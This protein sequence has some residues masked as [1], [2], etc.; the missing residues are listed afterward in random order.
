[1]NLTWNYVVGLF[2]ALTAAFI[3]GVAFA[4][5]PTLTP[6]QLQMLQQQQQQQHGAITSQ[7]QQ[8]SVTPRETIL[9]PTAPSA[10]LAQ[11]EM[12]RIL[13]T[14]SGM[15]LRQYGYDQLGVGRSV[16]LP[17][18]GAVQ[19]TYILG[20]G[21]EIVLTL[22]G[23]ENSEFRA[24][25][26][27]DGNV[28]F[29]R[30]QPIS[31]GGRSF[32]QF[33]Q[34]LAN[35][36]HRALVSTEGFVT[37]GRLRQIN[38]MVS[39][40]VG[41][42]GVRT[43]T[44]LSTVADAIFV[45]GGITKSGSL[46][47]V[48]LVRN[49]QERTVD[50][51][52]MLVGRV[53][54][55]N[56]TLTDGDKIIVPPVGATVAIAGEV[57]RPGIYELAAG[58]TTIRVRD[59][60]E[61]A[62][63]MTVPGSY[64]VSLLRTL[65]DGRRQMVDVTGGTGA[66]L[67]D[68]EIVFVRTSVNQSV[69]QVAIV[70]AVRAPGSAAIDKFKTIHDLLPSPD[71]LLPGAYL[72]FGFVER[73]DPVTLGRSVVPF[74]PIAVIQGK[75]NFPLKS[76]DTVHIL[77][78]DDMR[79]LID[80][81]AAPE[82]TTAATGKGPGV[83]G[84]GNAAAP[85]K[86]NPT[87]TTPS[88]GTTA[89]G[90]QAA[91]SQGVAQAVARGLEAAAANGTLPAGSA[92]D[93][94]ALAGTA[95]PAAAAAPAATTN[96][97]LV[98][99]DIIQGGLYGKIIADYRVI[100]SGA[101]HEP[102]IYLVYPGT[103]LSDLLVVAGGLTDDADMSSFELTSS[104]LDNKAGTSVTQRRVLPANSETFS[105]ILLKPYD[106]VVFHVIY[107]NR[108]FGA[109]KIAGEVLHPG[110]FDILRGEKLSSVLRRAGGFT[111]DGYAEGT[112]FRR[113]SVA[114]AEQQETD[115]ITADLRNQLLAYVMKPPSNNAQPLSA[116]AIATIEGLLVQV[117]VTR[118]MGRMPVVADLKALDEHPE[119]DTVLE[120]GDT[121]DIPRRPATVMIVGDVLRPGAQRYASSLSVGRYIEKAGGTSEQADTSRIIVVL[122]DGS[123]SSAGNSWL[124]FGSN[125]IPAGSTIYVPRKLEVY[126]FRQLLTDSIQIV[127][128]L[129]TTAAAL[130]VLSKQ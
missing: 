69:N 42:P 52:S 88:G 26:D 31:A 30:L 111:Q 6:D 83:P 33:R 92:G 37:I 2:G 4:Q 49:G 28:T 118:S 81:V 40:E 24:Q 48:R 101:V 18:I 119:L 102:G 23:Q 19:D 86:T 10:P 72:L 112:V 47:K 94:A 50:L 55:G 20:S 68:G 66:V 80:R 15:T 90:P 36:I 9:E 27:R 3:G 128:Q 56:F 105:S 91:A 74:S 25:V 11:S 71:V 121:I 65:P 53:R 75:T 29:P 116:E 22:R 79:D 103:P 58:Q 106:R 85:G 62:S 16:Y 117:S 113:T 108:N 8:Q 82:T 45:S 78:K 126:E 51:Y 89:A 44:G 93:I 124:N 12:E 5:V 32:G 107:S 109:V 96:S 60:V 125:D 97:G 21:D 59:A 1:M 34:D 64:I 123:V 114:E 35:A 110:S 122:P 100:V 130:A 43:L 98:G 127:S 87:T 129:A 39:G 120:P 57:R 84:A 70:G 104:E 99:I 54:S 41:S 17:Q 115:R 38:V 77:T 61:L 73:T 14:R 67:R 7:M 46:R 76:D 63:G 95:A 13:S